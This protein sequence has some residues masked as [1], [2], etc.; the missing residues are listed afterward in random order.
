MSPRTPAHWHVR[1]ISR[2]L[3]NVRSSRPLILH[4]NDAGWTRSGRHTSRLVLGIH[5]NS[6]ATQ[7][8]PAACLKVLPMYAT[9]LPQSARH[10]AAKDGELAHTILQRESPRATPSTQNGGKRARAH[11]P[12]NANPHTIC[13][14]EL[15]GYSWKTLPPMGCDGKSPNRP[16]NRFPIPG[17]DGRS[18]GLGPASPRT[19]SPLP[20]SL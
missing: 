6:T 9:L 12:P 19:L 7:D 8:K 3:F 13:V 4:Q 10:V 20:P 15:T 14:H 11:S 1:F 17:K 5:L 18:L 16:K 2:H